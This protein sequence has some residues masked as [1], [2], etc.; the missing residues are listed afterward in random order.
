MSLV[1]VPSPCLSLCLIT[2]VICYG[3]A[4]YVYP[5]EDMSEGA[6]VQ[7]KGRFKV[8]LADLS[9]KVRY[10]HYLAQFSS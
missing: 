1:V 2:V 9:P 7:R 4:A 5:A 3:F 10:Y 8:T 6:V